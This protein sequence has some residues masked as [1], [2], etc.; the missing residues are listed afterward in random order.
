TTQVS[1]LWSWKNKDQTFGVLLAGTYQKRRDIDYTANASSWHW[2]ADNCSD[3]ATCTQ[4]PTDV[5]GNQYDPAV[6]SNIDLWGNGE[7]DQSGRQYSGYWMPQQ[8]ST[9]RNQLD[10]K[11]KGV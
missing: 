2:W 5:H 11:T 1:A 7:V 8:F 4:P 10:L 3:H 9:S 6:P